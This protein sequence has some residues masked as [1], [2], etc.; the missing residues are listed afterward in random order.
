MTNPPPE[1]PEDKLKR[2]AASESKPKPDPEATSPSEP[3]TDPEATIRFR[4]EELTPPP[5][6]VSASPPS[7]PADSQATPVF[8]PEELIPPPKDRSDAPAPPEPLRPDWYRPEA[9][10]ASPPRK[11]ELDE[12]GMPRPAK[13]GKR[14]GRKDTPAFGGPIVF[15]PPDIPSD[16]ELFSE[17]VTVRRAAQNGKRGWG[18]CLWR[19]FVNGLIAAF[20]ASLVVVIILA[21]GYWSIARAL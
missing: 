9:E 16:A 8:K 21:Y 17:P 14:G 4:P 10:A 18:G 5:E 15:P 19:L 13:K 3:P 12:F 20:F 7:L 6:P 1:S 11:V 2:L